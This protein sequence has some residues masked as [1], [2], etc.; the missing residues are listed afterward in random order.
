MS[1]DGW[2]KA[3]DLTEFHKMH[4]GEKYSE[5][6]KA[7]HVVDVQQCA[8]GDWTLYVDDEGNYDKSYFSI[9]D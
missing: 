3:R 4:R 7:I 6:M 1:H 9:G 5:Y 8:Y 2:G